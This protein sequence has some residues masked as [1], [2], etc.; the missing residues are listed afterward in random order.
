MSIFG[1]LFGKDESPEQYWHDKG[2]TDASNETY[3]KPYNDIEQ[4]VFG[5]T[6]S[7]ANDAYDK[8]QDNVHDQQNGK[9]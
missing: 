5:N 3:H 4:I 2:E 1:N 8:G 7:K 6:A 9:C